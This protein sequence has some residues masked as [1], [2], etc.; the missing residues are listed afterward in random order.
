MRYVLFLGLSACATTLHPS[1]P[2]REP[3]AP[4][5][6]ASATPGSVTSVTET[7]PRDPS[8]EDEAPAQPTVHA[9]ALSAE[10]LLENAG[11]ATF[12]DD[13]GLLAATIDGTAM[14][15]WFS[16]KPSAVFLRAERPIEVTS[17]ETVQP[18]CRRV[19]RVDDVVVNE[20]AF[21]VWRDRGMRTQ[22]RLGQDGVAMLEEQLLD[23]A[24]QTNG[25]RTLAM[26][27]IAWDD[28]HIAY[29]EG[30][31]IHEVA[32]VPS[33]RHVA[34]TPGDWEGPR[35]HCV[36]TSLVVRPWIVPRVPH[37]GSVS[38]GHVDRF[39]VVPPGACTVECAPSACAEA[40][41]RA[42]LPRVPLYAPADPQLAVFRTEA[43]CRAATAARAA[44]APAEVSLP[45]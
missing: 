5:P 1:A 37:V 40:Q 39:P 35:G 29:A 45:W 17:G 20:L 36:D 28:A 34:C 9:P 16:R 44:T 12:L 43:A 3:T 27:P 6:S 19:Q 23:G 25:A 14:E 42:R 41:Q 18:D 24:W 21:V 15:R 33:L 38:P 10:A 2:A 30:A 11:L 13:H 26:G 8:S 22:V 7:P 31:E 32:C 4:L